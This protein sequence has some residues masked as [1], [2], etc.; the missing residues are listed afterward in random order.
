MIYLL[1]NYILYRIL[2]VLLCSKI[3]N[4]KENDNRIYKNFLLYSGFLFCKKLK[5]FVNYRLV[6][7]L[8]L[9][10]IYV[11]VLL[12]IAVMIFFFLIEF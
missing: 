3:V 6:K 5:L 10:Y 11:Y 9:L 12:D 4:V 8:Y 7:C 1:I 2:N